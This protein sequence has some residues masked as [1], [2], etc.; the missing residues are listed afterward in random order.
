MKEE[1]VDQDHESLNESE[2]NSES[3][4]S[5]LMGQCMGMAKREIR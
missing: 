4:K 2:F 1:N 3:W 5:G